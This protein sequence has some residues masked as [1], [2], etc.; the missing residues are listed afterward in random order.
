MQYDV[1]FRPIN[2]AE[3]D[4]PLRHE[5]GFRYFD[6]TTETSAWTWALREHGWRDA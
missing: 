6:F 1:S 2:E 4:A 3:R 5:D